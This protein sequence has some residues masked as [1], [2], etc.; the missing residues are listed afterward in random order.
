MRLGLGI[1]F[2]KN[3]T[4]IADFYCGAKGNLVIFINIVK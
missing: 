4:H 2:R 1:L 3:L